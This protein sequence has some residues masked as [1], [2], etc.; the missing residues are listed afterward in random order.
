MKFR[1]IFQFA[2]IG[3]LA[4]GVI[5]A[6]SAADYPT[7]PVSIIV[8]YGAGGTTDIFVRALGDALGRELKQPVV[9]ENKPGANG[10]MGV[11]SMKAAK[12]DGYSLT[13]VPISAFRQPYIQKTPYD[14]IKDVTYVSMVGSYNYAIAV[15]AK[16]QWNSIRELIYYTKKNPDTVFYGVNGR[17]SVTEFIMMDLAKKLG[18]KWTS[19]PFKGDS[20]NISSLLADQVQAVSATNAI[21]PFAQSGRVRVLA[22]TGEQRAKDFPDA[23][24]LKEAGYPLVMTTPF[25]IAGPAGLPDNIVKLLDSAISRALKDPKFVEAAGRYGIDITYMNQNTYTAYAKNAAV[26]EKDS[27]KTMLEGAVKN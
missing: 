11:I 26:H 13:I 23:P 25:G 6:A 27:V 19:V 14:P 22:T 10:T 8:P 9:V 16:S 18:L 20:E 2:A 24:T 7:R 3:I 21:L 4:S 15:N 17:Y 5:C 1:K 12:P